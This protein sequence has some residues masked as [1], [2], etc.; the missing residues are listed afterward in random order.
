MEG[1]ASIKRDEPRL[2]LNADEVG[3]GGRTGPPYDRGMTLS[4]AVISQTREGH[5]KLTIQS[6]QQ[7]E[8]MLVG[9]LEDII[10]ELKFAATKDWHQ[11]S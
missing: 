7:V 8:M 3:R 6:D 11:R 9:A 10:K 5:W 1:S 4:Q 2:V